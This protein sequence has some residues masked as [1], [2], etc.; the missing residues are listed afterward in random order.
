[1]APGPLSLFTNVLTAHDA[2]L[3]EARGR[4]WK[5][6]NG[7]LSFRQ[8]IPA[9]K[10][11]HIA[12]LL[13]QCC[14]IQNPNPPQTTCYRALSWT[15]LPSSIRSQNSVRSLQSIPQAHLYAKITDKSVNQV[16]VLGSWQQR[17]TEQHNEHIQRTRN[18]SSK[19][20]M[21]NDTQTRYC[22]T[23]HT[24]DSYLHSSESPSKSKSESSVNSTTSSS[25]SLS[26]T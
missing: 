17:S 23:Q 9:Y 25:G 7:S 1:M 24:D 18:A 6:A 8:L 22:C 19:Y 11:Y 26:V 4:G 20:S 14:I 16:I 3:A 13:A 12:T 5:P 2:S 15:P 10:I 21:C